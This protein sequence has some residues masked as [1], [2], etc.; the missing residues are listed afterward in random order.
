MEQFAEGESTRE[1]IKNK[2]RQNFDGKIV[3]KDLTKKI[4]EGAN[5]PVYVLEF[6]LGQYCSSDDET[7]IE[8]GVQNVKR[9]LADNF[10][11]PDES[12]KIL[13]QLRKKGSHTIIDMVT[14][15]LDMKKDCFFAEFSNLGVG[16]VPIA[17]EYPE[18]FDRLLCGG[19]WCIVQLDYEVEG[20]NNFGIEDID[21]NPLRSKQKKQKDISPISIR[22]LTPIQMPHIDIDELKQGRKAF[23]KDEWLDIL[24]RSIGMEPDE[25]TYR[26]KWLL[27]TRMIPLVENNFNL[28]ELGP[29]ST[30]KSHLYKEISPNS[31]LI[32]GGQTT[33][34]N[35]FYNM[36]RKTV[37]LVGL[38][39]CVAFDEV[40][41]IKFKDKDGIQ[42][43]KDY[44]A[45]GSFA[46][47]KEEKAATASMVFVG[48]INQSVDVLLKTSSLFAPFP[49]EMGTDTAFLD[50]MHCYLP[51]WEIP[52]F[53][54]EHFTDDYGFISD[55]LAEFIRELRKEQ[56]GDALDHYFR[57]GRNLN[58]R[59]T[60][61]V[62]RMID[63]Y[64]KLMYPNGEFTKEEL[65]EIIQIALEMRRRV[66]EQL[67][68]L[69]GME[70]YDVNFSYID[71]EDMSE[72]YVSV[73][74]QGGGKLIPDGMCNPGQVYT[75]SRGKSGM[76]GVFR[77]ESQ[78]LPGN[79]KIER[80]GLGSDSKCKEAVN[81]A[82]NYLKANGNR[83]SGS[84]S[85]STKDYII[86]YQDLQGIGMTDKL[87]LPTLIALCSIALGKPGGIFKALVG[88]EAS[89]NGE[90]SAGLALN[91]NKMVKNI[92]KN[93]ILT[94]FLKI[95][96]DDS[97][98]K[99]A[100]K[101]ARGAIKR[102]DGYII[103][104]EKDSLSYMV[105]VSPYLSMLKTGSFVP[106]G[107]FNIAIDKLENALKNAKGYYEF[108]GTKGK[109]K[110]ILRFNINSF[111]NGYTISDLLKMNL[112]I[113]A[114]KVGRTS[115]DMLDV[116]KEL[117][118]D[119]SIIPKDNPSYEGSN[120]VEDNAASQKILDVFDVLLAGVEAVD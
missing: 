65:E 79:G 16:N 82:F 103:S 15:R 45:S 112:S 41:G 83:I 70:F 19:I 30:G 27:L 91:R 58:Q 119:V 53:R 48:N 23:T 85:T 95:V 33:V 35:L 54:P 49:Q 86:N 98:K 97:A 26:E 25:F 66:K 42:I 18:K 17:D 29:R 89:A 10:V 90:I 3:R 120:E 71:L 55:Y 5:V 62:R 87:A 106:A 69:G 1:E 104:A 111:K 81:T 28:C 51:G 72:H 36:G 44:M 80:T 94:D 105:M 6:L 78:M 114:I 63:G 73:P 7:V 74:E 38:W 24:L 84:I 64:L 60:I 109:S 20:D 14:V 67:K 39:D 59:D 34:A 116:S 8:K 110:V 99:S 9:I 22:K 56:Y 4:K 77:L 75:V 46:R 11:R 52:K 102:F 100:S 2:L 31:I 57:L 113:Y 13:S 117:E 118:M 21:G 12:Q 107:E 96:D 76:I 93:T 50:R 92:M 101:T 108:V 115:L 40:A 68:K 47:G 88:W 61:A 32:S 37:G 43:M